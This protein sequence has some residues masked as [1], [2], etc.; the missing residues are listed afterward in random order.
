MKTQWS[1]YRNHFHGKEHNI[2]MGHE[3]DVPKSPLILSVMN[4][5][6]SMGKIVRTANGT[7]SEIHQ[8]SSE[9]NIGAIS[10]IIINC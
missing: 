3:V 9:S 7:C 6:S 2:Y 5:N 4:E 10:T 8:N 1:N